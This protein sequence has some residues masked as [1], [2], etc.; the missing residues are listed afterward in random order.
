MA[1]KRAQLSG[2]VGRQA[3]VD[4]SLSFYVVFLHSQYKRLREC[5]DLFIA[6]V[7]FRLDAQTTIFSENGAKMLQ[8][9]NLLPNLDPVGVMGW[10]NIAV[11]Y[12]GLFGV[13]LGT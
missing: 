3:A 13:F 11:T 7:I 8:E 2:T 4:I 9:F 10:C 6:G 12:T 5:L 1:T